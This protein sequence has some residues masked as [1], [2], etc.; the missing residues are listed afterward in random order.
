MHEIFRIF[1]YIFDFNNDTQR[2]N[3]R[4]N[5][6]VE[7]YHLV[8]RYHFD[9]KLSP[10]FEQFDTDQD[11]HYFGVWV[12]RE[13]LCIATYAEGD[14]CVVICLDKERYNAE[15]QHCI[16]FYGEGFI[17]KTFD[18]SGIEIFRQDRSKFLIP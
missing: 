6:V 10:R 12:S 1:P 2:K 14:F 8:D 17:G 7:T 9:L 13:L 18:E 4:G 15:I 3:E 16:S 11:A 5:I